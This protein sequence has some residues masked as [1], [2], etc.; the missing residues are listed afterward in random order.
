MSTDRLT[1]AETPVSAADRPGKIEAVPVRHYG[2]WV[3]VAVITV[4][5]LMFLNMIIFNPVF[6]WPFVFEVMNQSPVIDGLIKGTLLVTLFTMLV[7]IV[8][9]VILAVMR[10]SDNPIL[11]SVSWAYTWFFRS[12]P[13]IALGVPFDWKLIEWFG[14]SGDWRFLTLDANQIFSGFL[15]AV[16]GLGAS[17]AAYMAEIAPA[18]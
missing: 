9:G 2:R 13:R 7:G 10:L 1:A 5:V 6:N 8:G 12:V 4:L 18:R 16:I 3:A 15:G 14:L 17:E 11:R